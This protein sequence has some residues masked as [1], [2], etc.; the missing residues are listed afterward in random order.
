[1][2]FTTADH[3]YGNTEVI[4]KRPCALFWDESLL[5]GVM[6]RR[7]LKAAGIPF[8]LLRSEEIREGVLS[9]YRMIFVPG[10]W[11][12]NKIDAL[13]ERG[14]NEIRRFV[15]A[16]GS[17]LGICGGAGMG[18]ENGLG[19]LPIRRVPSLERVHGFNGPIRLFLTDH[20][21]WKNVKTP[22]FYAWWPSQF[23][24][25]DANVHV[26]ARYEE[27][28]PDAFA[29]DIRVADGESVGWSD[30]ERRYGIFL[31]PSRL[32]GE[33]AVIE[34]CYGRGRVILSLIHFDTPGDPNGTVVLQN[35]WAYLSSGG[36]VCPKTGAGSVKEESGQDLPQAVI[37]LVAEIRTAVGDLIAA[38]AKNF[39]WYWQN[40]L[41]LQWR[42][43]VRGLEYSTLAVMIGEI[44][45]R[46]G[47]PDDSGPEDRPALP[48]SLDLSRL[49]ENLMEIRERLLAFCE[50]AKRLL[51]KE[52]VYMMGASLS[53]V[54][55]EDIDISRL[56]HEL[57]GSA[58]S[59]GGE[60]KYIIDRINRL[61]YGLILENKP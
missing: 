60:F 23:R 40:P 47:K 7:A 22:V 32:N 34:G 48:E 61:L 14:L 39:L 57:F 19:L 52:R 51:D 46:L 50:K 29:S 8:N 30:L 49:Q 27:A 3:P 37:E 9:H 11:A 56:R 38:G 43:G 31:N 53:P 26:L 21:I 36:S 44:A 54:E 4:P 59:H 16:G 6:A 15:S 33:P 25:L 13:G 41:L 35:L 24:I 18:T 5:W 58:M 20:A 42:R 12:S 55:C 28:Q 1:M 45:S 2:A 17:Y 10:G